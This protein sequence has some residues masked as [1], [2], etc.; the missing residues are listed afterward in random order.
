[1]LQVR[2]MPPSLVLVSGCGIFRFYRANGLAAFS[3]FPT[4]F[5]SPVNWFSLVTVVTRHVER[6][7]AQKIH[8]PFHS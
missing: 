6:I 2:I 5:H 7:M 3:I 4:L 8:P 1:M